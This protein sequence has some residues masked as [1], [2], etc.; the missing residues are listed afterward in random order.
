MILSR[1][2]LTIFLC[3]AIGSF[4]FPHDTLGITIKEEK[5]LSKK[6]IAIILQRYTLIEDP[7]IVG[8]IRTIAK[9][10]VSV[11]PPQPYNFRFYVIQD[12]EYNAFATPGGYIF[13]NSGMIAAFENEGELAGVMAH[14]IAHVVCRHISQKV[15]RSKKMTMATLAGLAA[16]VLLGVGGAAA[17]TATAIGQSAMLAYSREDESQ[18]DQL[19]LTYLVDSGYGARGLM[20]GLEKIRSRQWFG[21]DDFPTYLSTHPAS[22][23]R[24]A[25]ID[26]WLQAH[27]EAAEPTIDIDPH[28]FRMAQTKLI[29][30]YGDET[31]AKQKYQSAVQQS[32]DDPMAHYGYALILAKTGDRP[33]A[34]EH[35]KKALEKRAFDPYILT[36]IG[37]LYYLQ[38]LYQ[39]ALDSLEGAVSISPDYPDGIFY[40]SK[41]YM[42]M[43][44]KK[45]AVTLLKNMIAKTPNHNLAR[46]AL[47]E[48]YGKLGEAG[49]AHYH[50]GLYYLHKKDAKN[51]HFH[52]KR[53]SQIIKDPNQLKKIDEK[54][55]I[56]EKKIS[57]D[58]KKQKG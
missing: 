24:I 48:A 49:Q 56:L 11:L 50:L 39:E 23:D 54:I 37:R 10:I 19:G 27:K 32:P 33:T 2:F 14:E 53:A 43:G 30:L 12:D 38:G 41:T 45:K 4:S 29:A 1:K 16:G 42:E 15:D 13:F 55:K 3:L 40:L 26:S 5:E 6:V 57:N 52:L 8:Y 20:T 34:I 44:K 36:D 9:R 58:Q 25:H 28:P 31:I 47:A 22:E 7:V 46:Y 17:L 51:A 21:S 35:L 18:A